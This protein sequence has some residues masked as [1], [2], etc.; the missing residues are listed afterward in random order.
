[1][2]Q[3][4]RIKPKIITCMTFIQISYIQ[5]IP[6]MTRMTFECFGNFVSEMRRLNNIF[7]VFKRIFVD[8]DIVYLVVMC[9]DNGIIQSQHR[10]LTQLKPDRNRNQ[11]QWTFFY[12]LFWFKMNM[13]I[14][15]CTLKLVKWNLYHITITIICN[16]IICS[17]FYGISTFCYNIIRA[18]THVSC[19]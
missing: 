6:N 7:I 16:V 18:H 11:P 10:T 9:G 19:N 3:P 4:Y 5:T 17:M 1:M 12:R 14:E 15:R 8:D 2:S 13:N